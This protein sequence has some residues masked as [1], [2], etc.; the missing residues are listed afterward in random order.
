MLF[1]SDEDQPT[2]RV[3]MNSL[4]DDVRKATQS[5]LSR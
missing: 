4:I 5:I 1:S 3:G 2:R